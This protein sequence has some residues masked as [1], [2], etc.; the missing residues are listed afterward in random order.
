MTTD[1]VSGCLTP[2]SRGG[3]RHIERRKATKNRSAT[4]N[5]LPAAATPRMILGS[6]NRSDRCASVSASLP[7]PFRIEESRS[8]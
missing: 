5:E 7:S 1:T 3:D 4:R 6:I 8:V 2:E